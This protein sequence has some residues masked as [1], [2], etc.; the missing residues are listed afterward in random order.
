MIGH[1]TNK[2][3]KHLL[4]VPA[5]PLDVQDVEQNPSGRYCLPIKIPR[6]TNNA[7]NYIQKTGTLKDTTGI[8]DLGRMFFKGLRGK[9]ES[10]QKR[11]ISR[12]GDGPGMAGTRC[13]VVWQCCLV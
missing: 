5:G 3:R 7:Q 8:Q 11:G 13:Q 4:Q 1:S 2:P 10:K 9:H 12:M 6:T